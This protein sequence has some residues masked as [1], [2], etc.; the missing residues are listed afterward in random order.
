VS[1]YENMS[2][3]LFSNFGVMPSDESRDLY[4]LASR[5]TEAVTVPAYTVQER[6][7]EQDASSGALFCEYDFFRVLY[8]SMA[9]SVLRS[10]IA[11]HMVLITVKDRK[12][13]TFTE[14]KREKIMENM[15]EVLHASLRR[16]DSAAR[17]S[18]QQY[19]V[20]LPRA[21]FENSQMVCER[22]LRAYYQRYSRADAELHYDVFPLQ[23]DEKEN[24]GWIQEKTER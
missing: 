8:F 13:G 23:P 17:C 7:K 15:K 22:I 19:V 6:L 10:G 4:R 14:K 1:V 11:V 24:F 21:N 12:G 2:E 20:M 9:R 16:G 18:A 5:D 3:L